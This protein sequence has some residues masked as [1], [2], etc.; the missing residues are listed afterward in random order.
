MRKEEGLLTNTITFFRDHV[1]IS[2]KAAE[3]A[4]TICSCEFGTG[5]FNYFPRTNSSY[6]HFTILL[7][8]LW[9]NSSENLKLC[10]RKRII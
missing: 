3:A 5:Q 10:L 1:I 6:D 7:E 9:P 4:A 8:E 2:E